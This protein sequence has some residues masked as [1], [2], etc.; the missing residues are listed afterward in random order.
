MLQ[1]ERELFAFSAVYQDLHED[2]VCLGVGEEGKHRNVLAPSGAPLDLLWRS[3]PRLPYRGAQLFDIL[4]F[5][6]EVTVD[7]TMLERNYLVTAE[8]DRLLAATQG[9]RNAARDRCLLL[10]TFR[11]GLRVVG[12]VR[13]EAVPGGRG[14]PGGVRQPLEERLSTT[15]PL[16]P[17]EIRAIRAWL[18]ERKAMRP[19]TDAFFVSERRGP[20]SRK[21]AWL[22]SA[23][24][25]S[26]P[27]C[28]C[29][30]I[31]NMLRHAC[32]YA[33]A[34]QAR[35]HPADPGLPRPPQHPAH[36]PL[37]RRQPGAV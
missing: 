9:S 3:V 11:H 20:L 17:E 29:P 4:E 14:Q 18:A 22:A 5:F 10:L 23:S 31:P 15:Q 19:A 37:H 24:A 6:Q 36:R 13:P 25:A 21:T 8:V 7:S 32:G 26:G 35:G 30:P 12:G 2:E 16:R 1:R 33:L 34:D 27:D 28:P